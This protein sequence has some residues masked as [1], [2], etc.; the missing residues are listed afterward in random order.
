MGYSRCKIN[1]IQP[2]Y[3]KL[4]Y[5]YVPFNQ[6]KVKQALYKAIEPT[7][8]DVKMESEF[9]SSLST[10]TIKQDKVRDAYICGYMTNNFAAANRNLK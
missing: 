1:V 6:A 10:I 8:A 7:T 4:A 2:A 9:F 3:K 5:C